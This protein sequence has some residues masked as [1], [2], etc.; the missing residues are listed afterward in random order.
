MHDAPMREPSACHFRSCSLACFTSRRSRAGTNCSG[1]PV[2]S[3]VVVPQLPAPAIDKPVAERVGSIDRRRRH[4]GSVDQLLRGFSRCGGLNFSIH[5]IA[6]TG[7]TVILAQ[8]FYL[9]KLLDGRQAARCC[10]RRGERKFHPFL[11]VC[12]ECSGGALL[13]KCA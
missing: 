13:S 7:V 2:L 12:G 9:S 4:G 5:D 10:G 8:N 11:V 3:D 6:E 1:L